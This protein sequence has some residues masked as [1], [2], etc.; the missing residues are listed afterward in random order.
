M[1]FPDFILHIQEKEKQNFP[2]SYNFETVIFEI[3]NQNLSVCEEIF[4]RYVSNNGPKIEF[5]NVQS[6]YILEKD[7]IVM[8]SIKHFKSSEEYYY[9]LFHELA[10][11][12]IH[13]TR[14]DRKIANQDEAFEE[15]VAEL[16]S[17]IITSTLF[18]YIYKDSDSFI[19]HYLNHTDMMGNKNLDL[20]IGR[21][22][23][24]SVSSYILKGG[25]P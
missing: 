12:T 2:I 19:R 10:H 7:L 13:E 5:R 3:D 17:V 14:L 11:S 20:M 8:P 16:S 23:A 22:I 9:I 6:K 25:L 21:N 18:N 4:F 1:T 15:I 24:E